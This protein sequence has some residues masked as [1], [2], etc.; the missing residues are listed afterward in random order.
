MKNPAISIKNFSKS[1]FGY[2]AVEDLTFNVQEGSIMA[3]LG[4]N[5]A[6]KTTTIRCLLNIYP[7]DKG[8]L[9]V[10]DKKFNYQMNSLI[11]YLP[12]ERGIYQDVKVYDFFLYISKL[13]SIPPDIAEKK[14]N[15]YLKRVDLFDHKDKQTSQL[16]SGMQQKVQI[17]IAIIHSPKLLILDEPFRGLDPI[18]R[19]LFM[20]LFQ[21]MNEKEGTTLLFSTHVVDEA[22]KLSDEVTIIK[23][24]KLAATGTVDK[25]RTDFGRDTINIT[26]TGKFEA[27]NDSKNLF[28]ARISNKNAE[29]IPNEKINAEEILKYLVNSNIGLKEFKI[30]RPSLNEV[31]LEINKSK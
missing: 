25:L 17:G 7:S 13:R 19:Q 20:D 1:F 30:D 11:G 27:D 29:I 28:E 24:G 2:K 23:N 31:F 5:G 15:A 8:E 16:S 6:G 4:A 10:F 12:E 18:N 21:E 26:Y 22:Q 14:I 9:L 3:F